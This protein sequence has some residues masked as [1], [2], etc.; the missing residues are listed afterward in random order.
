MYDLI[1]VTQS[2]PEL[3]EMT[4]QC[5]NSA[6]KDCDLR[7]IVV[8]TGQP[9]KYD[10]DKIVEYNG[11][12]N[13]NRALNLGLKYAKNKFQILANNDL[14]FREGWS[15]IG[16][17]MKVNG[18]LSA[19][20]LSND[21]RQLWFKRGNYAYEGYNIGYQLA[22]WCIFTDKELWTKIGKLDE[23]HQ[24][25]F[26]D[27]VYAEQLK[28]ANIKH[29]LICSVVVDHLGSQT[30]KKQS[31]DVQRTYTY[32]QGKA[33]REFKNLNNAKRERVRKGNT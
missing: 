8:E 29:A 20:A 6:R 31:R 5:I 28:K 27:N 2:S 16:D 17:I 33:V 25:W 24:F 13:Y 26:S 11:E 23:T 30:L 18:Y 15:K 3:I 12:F 4:E 32:A 22:G 9:Y 19:S 14:I 21:Q 1:I 7:V 10:A